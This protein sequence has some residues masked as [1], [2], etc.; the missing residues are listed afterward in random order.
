MEYNSQVPEFIFLFSIVELIIKSNLQTF[1]N[2]PTV[3][4]EVV[5]C[6]IIILKPI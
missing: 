4:C 2:R 1:T 6:L 3:S 5:L